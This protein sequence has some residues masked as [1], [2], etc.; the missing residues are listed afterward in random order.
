[1]LEGL[2]VQGPMH[3]AIQSLYDGCLLSVSTSGTSGEGWT[4]AMGYGRG[5][6]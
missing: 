5:A 6:A 2:G 3:G 4:P 1:M